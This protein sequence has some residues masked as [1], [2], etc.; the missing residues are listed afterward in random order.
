[1]H[2]MDGRHVIMLDRWVDVYAPHHWP[3][4][5]TRETLEAAR[6]V[7]QYDG[8]PPTLLSRIGLSARRIEPRPLLNARTGRTD[9]GAIYR[10]EPRGD[11]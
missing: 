1:M 9:A 5:V 4:T 10:L 11:G 8:E 2:H 7:G 6:E 3:V